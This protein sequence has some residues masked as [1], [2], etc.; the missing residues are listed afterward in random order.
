MLLLRTTAQVDS[1]GV[2]AALMEEVKRFVYGHYDDQLE[3]KFYAS[4]LAKDLLQAAVPDPED[5]NKPVS[6]QV[7][8][9]SAYFIRHHPNNNVADF[10]E[11]LPPTRSVRLPDLLNFVCILLRP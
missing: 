5:S 9:E 8:W 1:H 11:I 6:D 10:P 7:D 3:D 4:G 2:D